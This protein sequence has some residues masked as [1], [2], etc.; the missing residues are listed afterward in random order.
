MNTIAENLRVLR[1]AVSEACLR[2]G[3]N[4]QDIRIIAVS[5]TMSTAKIQDAANA[6]LTTF[7]ENYVQEALEK[8]HSLPPDIHW[9]FIG[10]IQKN[11][12]KHIVRSFELIHSVGSR[13][14]AAGIDRRAAQADYIQPVLFE[15]NIAGETTKSGF[16]PDEFSEALEFL[17]ALKHIRPAGL[18]TM[19]PPTDNETELSGYFAGLRR[20]RDSIAAKGVFG[21]GFREL[22]MGTSSD[23]KIAIKEGATMIRVGTLLFGPRG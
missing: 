1:E 2:A 22:S 13:E 3:R 5:K 8:I 10:N 12:V 23:Y 17:A 20:L 6:G 21:S 19:P 7:G 15:I 14:T 18:M 4:E 9:H 11:K 16:S